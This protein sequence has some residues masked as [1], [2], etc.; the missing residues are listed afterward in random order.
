[1]PT[2]TI[3][4]DVLK[5]A[6]TDWLMYMNAGFSPKVAREQMEDD[7]EYF[8]DAEKVELSNRML[9]ELEHRL[10]HNQ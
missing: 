8:S 4:R 5:H 2:K 7:Y 6:Y 3:R 9:D 1:M 10:E